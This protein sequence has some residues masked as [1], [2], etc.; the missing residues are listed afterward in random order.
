MEASI[1]NLKLQEMR[2]TESA[3]ARAWLMASSYLN[4]TPWEKSVNYVNTLGKIKKKDIIKFANE[5]L[6]TNNYVIVYKRQGQPDD[7]A[8]IEKPHIPLYHRLQQ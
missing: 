1:N 5:H 4:N 3:R 2:R 7:I 8:K 6:G